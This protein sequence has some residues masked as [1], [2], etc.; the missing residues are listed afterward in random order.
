MVL[1]ENP[2]IFSPLTIQ[3]DTLVLKNYFWLITLC[4][5]MLDSFQNSMQS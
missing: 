1:Y 2:I 4:F 3:I 5:E